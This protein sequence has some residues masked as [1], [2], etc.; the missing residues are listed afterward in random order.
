MRSTAAFFTILLTFGLFW[1]PLASGQAEKEK[2]DAKEPDAKQAESKQ[3]D[4]KRP[5]QKSEEKKT[6]SKP[7]IAVFTLDGP[8]TEKPIQEDFPLAEP[9]TKTLKDLVTRLQKARDDQQVKAVVFL[10]DEAFLDLAQVEELRQAVDSFKAA[11]KKVYVHVDALLDTKSYALAAGASELSATP[12]AILMLTG[13]SAESPY[14]RGLLDWIGVKPDFLTCGEYKTAAETFMRKAP[15]PAAERMQDWLLDSLYQNYLEMIAK[16]RNLPV[17][18]ARL[19]INEGLYTPEKAKP[20]G[21]ID[22]VEHRQELEARLKAEFGQDLEFKKD[23]GKQ[24]KDEIDLSSPLAM[25][26]IWGEILQGGKKKTLPAN[27]VAVVYVEGPI[28]PGKAEQS[29]FGGEYGAYSTTIR[30]ALD[31]AAENDNVK[32]VVLRVNS[33]GGSAVASEIILNATKRVAAKKPLVVSMGNVA[34]SGGYYV[35]C[36]TDTIFA[37]ATTITASIGV[38]GG[39]FATSDL[40]SK[41][42]I[43]WDIDQRGASAGLL[44]TNDVFSDEEREKMQDWMNEVY[45]V[46]KGHVVASRGKKLKKPIDELAGG[47]VFTGKQALDLGLVDRIGTLQDAIAFVAKKANLEDYET[48]ALPEPKSFF[49]TLFEEMADGKSENNR[50]TLETGPIASPRPASIVELALPH[51]QGLDPMRVAEVTRALRRL[52]MLQQQRVLMMMPEIAIRP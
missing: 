51:L 42:G 26:K 31:K 20:L 12:T 18:Q 13:F 45:G 37:D 32:A 6:A 35:A 48:V 11:G 30:K 33:P 8:I 29:I 21:V 23:Y 36:G 39:K 28:M 15:S 4:A 27:S 3:S 16:G 19:W 17:E 22:R 5:A 46:F 7:I 34:G 2:A 38:V 44:S 14:L 52:D 24:K 41:I 10:L 50:L 43:H 1:A 25:F 9:G 49:E 47:R 40:W